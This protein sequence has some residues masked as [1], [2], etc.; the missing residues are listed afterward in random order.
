MK[1]S[2]PVRMLRTAAITLIVVGFVISMVCW[3]EMFGRFQIPGFTG[4]SWVPPDQRG[5]VRLLASWFMV[6][7]FV[8]SVLLLNSRRWI[9]FVGLFACVLYMTWALLPVL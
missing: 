6:V 1:T 9:A 2:M 3:I 4:G 8:S 7:V 5:T